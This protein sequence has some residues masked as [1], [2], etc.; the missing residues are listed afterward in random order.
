MGDTTPLEKTLAAARERLEA[1]G[2]GPREV[3]PSE[4]VAKKGERQD[5][6]AKDRR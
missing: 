4:S 3:V 5:K 6:L 1:M 2:A